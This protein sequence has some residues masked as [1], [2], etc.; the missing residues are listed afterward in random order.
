MSE[1]VQLQV[2]LSHL[3]QGLL[4]VLGSSQE[5]LPVSLPV[6]LPLVPSAEHDQSVIVLFSFCFQLVA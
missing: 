2:L 1:Q 4:P 3:V 6:P 5:L